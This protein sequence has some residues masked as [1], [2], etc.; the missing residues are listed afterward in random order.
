MCRVTCQSLRVSTQVHPRTPVVRSHSPSLS[1]CLLS[2]F[3]ILLL[4]PITHTV[5]RGTVSR[6]E[7]GS[8]GGALR[9]RWQKESENSFDSL[10]LR[11]RTD[12]SGSVTFTIQPPRSF[13]DPVCAVSVPQVSS[14]G[15]RATGPTP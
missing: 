11:Y 15:G 10:C 7:L 12:S 6:E 4:L 14:E 8:V 5:V 13:L 1:S 9:P 3:V 2:L